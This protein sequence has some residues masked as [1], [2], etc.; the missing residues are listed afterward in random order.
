SLFFYTKFCFS[1]YLLIGTI[2]AIITLLML[3]VF[4]LYRS[5]SKQQVIQQELCEVQQ[6]SIRS[7]YQQPS[8]VESGE[9][10]SIDVYETAFP[11]D[12]SPEW[13]ENNYL[14]IKPEIKLE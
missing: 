11:D 12:D 5:I 9:Y 6:A 1:V 4:C 10:D 2:F 7:H 8:M 3:L 13:I 14:T